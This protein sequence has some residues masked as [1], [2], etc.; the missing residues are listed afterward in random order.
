VS[1][2][3]P[4]PAFLVGSGQDQLLTMARHLCNDG[5]KEVIRV[6][7]PWTNVGNAYQMVAIR[8][9][10]DVAPSADFAIVRIEKQSRMSVMK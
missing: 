3:R 5:R 2:E 4:G 1:R 10:M 8:V 7:H 9:G 6:R